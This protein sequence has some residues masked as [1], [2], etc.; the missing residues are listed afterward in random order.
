LEI[1][2]TCINET[3][4]C[5]ALDDD[6]IDD[7]DIFPSTEFAACYNICGKMIKNKSIMSIIKC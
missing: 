4:T 6:D 1:F 7:D 2:Y 3:P 5:L